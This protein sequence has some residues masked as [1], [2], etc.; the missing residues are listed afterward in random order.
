[1]I[2]SYSRT[3]CALS[4]LQLMVLKPIK[5]IAFAIAS[6][7]S[8][9]CLCKSNLA[10]SK[11][12]RIDSWTARSKHRHLRKVPSPSVNCTTALLNWR[13]LTGLWTVVPSIHLGLHSRGCR[14]FASDPT[15]EWTCKPDPGRQYTLTAGCGQGSGCCRLWYRGEGFNSCASGRLPRATAPLFAWSVPLTV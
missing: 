9:D 13:Y 11:G 2:H 15:S 12:W 10:A 7:Y 14:I 1:M 5:H 3:I 8:R 6:P 4:T